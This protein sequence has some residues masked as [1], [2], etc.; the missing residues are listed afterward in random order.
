MV[1]DTLVV[2][3]TLGTRVSIE[4]TIDSVQRFGRGRCRHLIVGPEEAIL[5]LGSRYGWLHLLDDGGSTGIYGAL[6][7]AIRVF[8]GDY[9]YFA[10]INDDD[11]WLEGYSCL[12][13]CLDGD[14][15]VGLAYGKTLL[16][17]KDLQTEC[18]WFPEWKHFGTLLDHGVPIFSQQSV[19][20]RI[21]VLP[22]RS[23]FNER[24]PLSADSELWRTLINDGVKCKALGIV[25]STSK[26]DG[27]R[28]SLKVEMITEE[29]EIRVRNTKEIFSYCV[30]I[31]FRLYNV[32]CYARRLAKRVFV[33]GWA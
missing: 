5:K 9:R 17:K 30:L 20:C 4:K 23:P 19:L 12:F 16:E 25:C 6:N 10:Y 13:D 8:G 24:Y 21:D 14:E 27:D 31:W 3:P 11:Q 2:T 18:A 29:A 32:C 28:L 7:K 26:M 1:Y 22:G 15:S 33:K